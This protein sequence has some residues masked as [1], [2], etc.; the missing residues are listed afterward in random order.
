MVTCFGYSRGKYKIF[1][2]DPNVL[3]YFT[4]PDAEKFEQ[5]DPPAESDP[6]TE[7][8]EFSLTVE[9]CHELGFLPMVH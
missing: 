5:V 2:H 6:A 7:R 8:V 3:L 4:G 9:D 1:E